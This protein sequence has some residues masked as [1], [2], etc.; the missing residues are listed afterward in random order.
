ML[1]KRD[2]ATERVILLIADTRANRAV[3]RA[4]GTPL[5]AEA[6]DSR[7]ILAGLASGQDPAGSAVIL[8]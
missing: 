6:L 7:P 1:K 2:T 5:M 8:L 4:L 3:L